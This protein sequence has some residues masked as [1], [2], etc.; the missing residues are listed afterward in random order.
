MNAPHAI[1]VEDY[2][3][4]AFVF[5]EALKSVGYTTEIITDGAV[6]SQRLEQVVPDVVILDLHIPN[7]SGEKILRQIRADERLKRVRVMIATADA[8]FGENLRPLA[9]LVLLKPVSFG[10]L[11]EL[12]KRFYNHPR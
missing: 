3:D 10:Q 8:Q 12:A 11:A 7:V 9:D 2:E 6:A 1:V 5:S 4:L